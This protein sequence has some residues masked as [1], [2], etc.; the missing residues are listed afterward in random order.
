[1]RQQKRKES[2][3]SPYI[4]KAFSNIPSQDNLSCL[5]L[6]CSDGWLL[7]FFGTEIS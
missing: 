7:W 5:D 2:V 6:F 1:M 4:K 3:L